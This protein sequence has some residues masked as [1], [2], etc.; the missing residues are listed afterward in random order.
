MS[1]LS[2]YQQAMLDTIGIKRWVPRVSD[3][4]QKEMANKENSSLKL[5]DQNQE[6][7]QFVEDVYRFLRMYGVNTEGVTW[8]MGEDFSFENEQLVTPPVERL[9]QNCA[10][11]RELYHF[12]IQMPH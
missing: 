6:N 2:E 5:V 11:K 7:K 1:Q 8:F 3:A 10:L 9:M 12:I 4:R